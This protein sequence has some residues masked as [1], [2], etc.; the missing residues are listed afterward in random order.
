MSPKHS[1]AISVGRSLFDNRNS[2]VVPHGHASVDHATRRRRLRLVARRHCG[3][4]CVSDIQVHKRIEFMEQV[5]S[6][7]A[8][9]QGASAIITVRGRRIMMLMGKT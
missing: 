4:M 9:E 5:L 3:I 2:I 8:R 6:R 7:H 1:E